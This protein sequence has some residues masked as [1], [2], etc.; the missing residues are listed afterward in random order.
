MVTIPLFEIMHDRVEI[1]GTK[2]ALNEMIRDPLEFL[3]NSRQGVSSFHYYVSLLAPWK[4][5]NRALNVAVS[6]KLRNES[7]NSRVFGLEF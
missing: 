2:D 7:F 5:V 4:D 1:T 6:E 3:I